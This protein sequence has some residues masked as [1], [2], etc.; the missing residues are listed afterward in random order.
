MLAFPEI[1]YESSIFFL[2]D[3][4]INS[5]VFKLLKRLKIENALFLPIWFFIY[6]F[7]YFPSQSLIVR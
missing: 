5:S 6:I 4:D 1:F 3:I 7:F 2:F